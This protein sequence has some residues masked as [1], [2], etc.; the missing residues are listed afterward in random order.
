MRERPGRAGPVHPR[1]REALTEVTAAGG[2]AIVM[3]NRRGWSPFVDC[4][5]CGWA[6]GCPSCDVSLVSHAWRPALSPLRPPRA[7]AR[8]LSRVRLGQPR[9]PWGRDRAGARAD[10]RA[11]RRPLR[12]SGWTPTP[13]PVQAATARSSPDSTLRPP[14]C[15]WA[16]RWSPR[17]TTSPRSCSAWC[18]TPTP[19]LRFP[20]FRAEE[21]TF[22]L[23]AQLAGRSGRGDGGGRVLVQTLAPDADAIRHAA[24]HDAP[25]FLAGEL[26]R[27]EAL[28]Y[29]PFSNLI[30][31]QTAADDPSAWPRMRRRTFTP[32]S[33]RRCPTGRRCSARPRGSGCG[34]ATAASS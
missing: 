31:V 9:P 19:R 3:L 6:A 29:P 27:R 5:S 16:R 30:R 15:C 33:R 12:C 22:S 21:R 26:S 24:R 7:D 14:G 13:R 4:R 10:L 2:K 34:G 1:T 20:D 17:A 32:G 11:G 18:S 28:G 25:G 23:V 8:R